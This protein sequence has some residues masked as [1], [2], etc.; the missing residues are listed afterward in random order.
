MLCMFGFGVLGTALFC[1]CLKKCKKHSKKSMERM[2]RRR[3]MAR[4]Q[5]IVPPQVYVPQP[6]QTETLNSATSF[7]IDNQ[8]RFH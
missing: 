4:F 7:S 2:M 5:Q 8:I 6:I 1:M 3:E